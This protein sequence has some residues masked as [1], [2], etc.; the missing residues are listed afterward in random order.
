MSDTSTADKNYRAVEPS[1]EK[2]PTEYN[3]VERRAEILDLIEEAGHPD[4]LTKTRL[5]ERYDVSNSQ[6]TKDFKRIRSYIKET[7]GHQRH[8]M[9]EALYQKAIRH[10]VDNN[11]F[12]KAIAAL[13]SYNDW[14]REEGVRDAD[15]DIERA[16]ATLADVLGNE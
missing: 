7:L 4:A 9:S 11:D 10:H 12:N 1:A 8:A 6:I 5:A 3:Y 16:G 14:L 13:E 2:P 15:S